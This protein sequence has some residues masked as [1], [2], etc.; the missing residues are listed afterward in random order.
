MISVLR[1]AAVVGTAARVFPVPFLIDDTSV[2]GVVIFD[3]ASEK[4]I[5]F[6]N[7][8]VNDNF[9]GCLDFFGLGDSMKPRQ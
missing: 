9:S 4:N 8:P 1:I 3:G 2:I 5:I 6:M 7:R